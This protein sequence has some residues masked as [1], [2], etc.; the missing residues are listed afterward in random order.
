[1]CLYS[2]WMADN[3]GPSD[4]QLAPG[5]FFLF[6]QKLQPTVT[7]KIPFKTQTQTL[8]KLKLNTYSNSNPVCLSSMLPQEQAFTHLA[9]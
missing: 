3:R 2:F 9:P 1:M 8:L 5:S 4:K 6:L 7:P